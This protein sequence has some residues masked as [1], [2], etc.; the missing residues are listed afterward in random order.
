MK[1]IN[2]I[3]Q[4]VKFDQLGKYNMKNIFLEKS[5]TKYGRETIPRPF[6]KNSKLTI[7]L[8]QQSKVLYKLYKTLD[9]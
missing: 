6:N 3:Y 1:S 5:C 9:Y 8:D 2:E 7:S 4:S